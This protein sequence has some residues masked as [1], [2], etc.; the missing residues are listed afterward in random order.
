ME[1]LI[2]R[3]LT[4]LFYVGALIGCMLWSELSFFL[5]FAHI[6]GLTVWEFTTNVNVHTGAEV[7]RF[8][9]TAGAV[10][11]VAASQLCCTVQTNYVHFLPF[12][13][14]IIYLLV[15]E[16]YR[17]SSDP[18]L[19][20]SYSFAALLY[21]ALPFALLFVLA[22]HF[23]PRLGPS[24]YNWVL[25]LSLFLF[26]WTNDTGAYLCGTLLSRYFPARL[27]PRISPH[28]SWVGSIGGGILVL[29]MA[30]TLYYLIP[31]VHLNLA[32]W[33]GFGFTVCVFGTWGDLVESLFKRRLGIK[34][35][36]RILPGHGGLLDR[37]DSALLAIPATVI[38]FQL[39]APLLN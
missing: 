29:L 33:I 27:F 30:A 17:K 2:V 25:P 34:D 9:T 38:Y 28:K 13:G 37:F 16:L 3:T 26:L 11:F 1:N 24:G 14:T 19:N 18:L 6:A 31:S 10:A 36:G 32:Q 4:A 12:L 35:S 8:I 22:Y 39:V 5:F 20:W 15:S 21:I 7:N 23:D